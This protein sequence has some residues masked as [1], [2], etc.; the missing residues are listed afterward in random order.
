MSYCTNINCS[1][2]QNYDGANFCMSCGKQILL[3]ERYRPL[4]LIG[5]GGFGRTFL[6]TDE[7]IPS[8]PKCVIKQLYFPQTE[9]KQN[10]D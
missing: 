8:K 9:P 4:H 2:P 10:N 1:S 7:Y 3:K 6:S 5:H